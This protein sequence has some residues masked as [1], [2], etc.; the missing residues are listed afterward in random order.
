MISNRTRQR[1]RIIIVGGW[2]PG[3]LGYLERILSAERA[4]D[5]VHPKK[6][7][8][9]MPP[10]PGTWCCHPYV[11]LMTFVLGAIIYLSATAYVTIFLRLMMVV[12][13]LAWSRLLVGVVVRT[14]IETSIWMICREGLTEN[15]DR[16]RVLVIGFSWGGAIVA[17]MIARGMIGGMNQSSALL[18]APTTSLVAKVALQPDAATRIKERAGSTAQNNPSKITVV[19]GE[20][21]AAFCPNQ[22]RWNF[23]PGV[24]LQI[25]PDNHVFLRSSS[26]SAL[27]QIM[28]HH[29][30]SIRGTDT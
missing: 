14:S 19:H 7:S 28:Q 20:H 30:Q 6:I 10:F 3:P 23:V 27:N 15:I 8:L 25:L 22:D 12:L 29:L 13:A 26:L 24:D 11:L 17:E 18:I 9:W 21:D 4:H 16:D 2:S 1:I 5:I